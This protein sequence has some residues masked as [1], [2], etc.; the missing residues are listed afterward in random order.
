MKKITANPFTFIVTYLISLCEWISLCSIAYFSLK[1]F[2]YDTT[3]VYGLLEWA[4]ILVLSLIL[5][6][7]IS[8]IPTPGNSGAADLSFFLL[9]ETGLFAGLAF[10]AMV[11]WRGLSFYSFIIIGFIF[12]MLKKKFDNKTQATVS[13]KENNETIG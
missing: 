1:F 4:Q 8:F 6:A 5:Y 7:A 13:Q 12:A 3:S 10:P 9:F 11:V 2:G